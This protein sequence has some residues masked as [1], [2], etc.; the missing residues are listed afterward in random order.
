MDHNPPSIVHLNGATGIYT[1]VGGVLRHLADEIKDSHINHI[2]DRILPAFNFVYSEKAEGLNKLLL[3]TFAW[4]GND[5]ANKAISHAEDILSV[6]DYLVII[7]YSFP[8]FNREIDKRIL[9]KGRN[10]KKIFLQ[11]PTADKAAFATTF[12]MDQNKVHEYK[13]VDQFHIPFEA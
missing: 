9:Q 10:V 3:P 1:K 12:G 11:N 2:L 5:A 4:E 6:T 8:V 7:G 13:N